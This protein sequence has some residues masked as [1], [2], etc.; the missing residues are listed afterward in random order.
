MV[1]SADTRRDRGAPRSFARTVLGTTSKATLG[2]ASPDLTLVS[3]AGQR[4]VRI[5]DC[6]ARLDEV[7]IARLASADALAARFR[8]LSLKIFKRLTAPCHQ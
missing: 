1:A 2:E 8:S 5:E 4:L 7:W 6:I 3:A